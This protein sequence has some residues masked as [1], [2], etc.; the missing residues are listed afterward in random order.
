[1]SLE[2]DIEALDFIIMF[3]RDPVLKND[4][5]VAR[6]MLEYAR[7]FLLASY[8]VVASHNKV[9]VEALKLADQNIKFDKDDGDPN[10][11]F[12]E[13]VRPYSGDDSAD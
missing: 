12:N 11:R 5:I 3:T 13:D 4:F 1:M 2:T 7:Y 8:D 10:D 9:M 6:E